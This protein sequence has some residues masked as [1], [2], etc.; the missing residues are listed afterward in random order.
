MQPR[1]SG[2]VV[3]IAERCNLNCTYCYMYQHAD[4]SYRSRPVFMSEEVFRALVGRVSDYSRAH[5]QYIISLTFH[6]GEPMLFDPLKLDA[7]L[8]EAREVL[9]DRVK[10]GMQTNA[11]Q[12]TDKWLE[13]LAKHR[14]QPGVS[15]DGPA[16]VH[17]SARVDHSGNGSFGRAVAG[18]RRLADAGL[19]PGILCVINPRHSGLAAYHEFRS[20]GFKRINFLFPEVTHDTKRML[21][22]GLGATPV[23]DYLIPIFDEWWEEDDPEVRIRLFVE[24][25]RLMF[26]ATSQI[27]T[28]GGLQQ[29][30]LV[31]DTDG[32]IQGNDC[33]KICYEGAPETGLNVLEHGFDELGK[34]NPL[35]YQLVREG[36]P[37]C[38]QCRACP[39]RDVCGGSSV[40]QRYSRANGFA[41]PSAWCDDLFKLLSHIRAAVASRLGPAEATTIPAE[42]LAV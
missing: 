31:I 11:T 26:G 32:S 40:P 25:I 41:N 10:F 14:V 28:L 39:E 36:L 12:V 6:G 33:L 27:D 24:A 3:K 17:D 5:P 23:A 1:I 34:G 30:Y 16:E 2:L 4:Q 20:L 42:A 21:Y 35:I 19:D 38:G 8:T 7:W 9:G 22:S 29:D 37:L 18:L 13:V 15:L